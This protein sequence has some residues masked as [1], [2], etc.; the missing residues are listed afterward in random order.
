[1]GGGV[2][3]KRQKQRRLLIR[4]GGNAAGGGAQLKQGALARCCVNHSLAKSASMNTW[5][6]EC[7]TRGN[8]TQGVS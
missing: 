5:W 6:G 4:Q 2:H 8:T 3:F 1:M 7:C